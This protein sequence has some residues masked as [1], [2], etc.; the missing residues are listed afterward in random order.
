[1]KHTQLL[2][3]I[4]LLLCHNYVLAYDAESCL[5]CDGNGSV[6]KTISASHYKTCSL[7]GRRPDLLPPLAVTEGGCFPDPSCKIICFQD[8]ASPFFVMDESV[9]TS[10]PIK[11]AGSPWRGFHG[12]F[13]TY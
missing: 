7:G 8:D 2:I 4:I 11:L 3:V 5:P 1:M 6:T 12:K 10:E 9:T 13:R